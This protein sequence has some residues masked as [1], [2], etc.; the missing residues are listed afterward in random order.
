VEVDDLDMFITKPQAYG[1]LI[2]EGITNAVRHGR[3]TSLHINIYSDESGKFVTEIIDNGNGPEN[4][5]QGI[6]SALFEVGTGGNWSL[7]R[8][9]KQKRT[10]LRLEH[11]ISN[12]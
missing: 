8:D 3:C 9:S 4:Y 6:G 5:K 10:T 2:E 12:S 1:D 11:R 7:T